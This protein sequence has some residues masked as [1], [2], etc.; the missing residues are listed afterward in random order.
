[1]VPQRH[2]DRGESGNSTNTS[3]DIYVV[4]VDVSSAPSPLV[5]LPPGP[6]ALLSALAW[7]PDG[8]KIVLL[9]VDSGAYAFLIENAD[10]TGLAPLFR[11]SLLSSP[12]ALSPDGSEISCGVGRGGT[13]TLEAMAVDGGTVG[14]PRTVLVVRS[15]SL[16]LA[17]K[18]EQAS[19]PAGVHLGAPAH[20][21]CCKV[22]A[23]SRAAPVTSWPWR[24]QSATEIPPSQLPHRGA[25][26]ARPARQC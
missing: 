5:A 19:P 26:P 23:L 3:C 25:G 2:K 16:K 22:R 8:K 24:A 1:M 20:A 14:A 17:V 15:R 4:P 6:G 9:G 13:C 10:G 11:R 18:R 7:S 12:P 21:G